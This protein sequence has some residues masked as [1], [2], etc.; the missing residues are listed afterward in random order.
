MRDGT[1]R[2]LG[3]CCAGCRGPGKTFVLNEGN[4]VEPGKVSEQAARG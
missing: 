1:E 4:S 2:S 3:T